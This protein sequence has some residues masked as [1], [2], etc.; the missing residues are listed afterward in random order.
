MLVPSAAGFM[1]IEADTLLQLRPASFAMSRGYEADPQRQEL[2]FLEHERLAIAELERRVRQ[3]RSAVISPG[4]EPPADIA[5]ILASSGTAARAASPAPLPIAGAGIDARDQ[6]AASAP[7]PL[8][9]DDALVVDQTVF[10][11]GDAIA[12]PGE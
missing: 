1:M 3:R 12:A 5:S 7:V 2:Q 10:R 9:P 11:L 6:A 4:L 8:A